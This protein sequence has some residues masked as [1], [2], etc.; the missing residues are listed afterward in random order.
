M[1]SFPSLAAVALALS[2]VFL[3]SPETN[4]SYRKGREALDRGGFREAV[5]AFAEAGK[6]PAVADAALYWQAYALAKLSESARALELVT[7][8]ENR[9]PQS[10]WKDDAQSL[11]AEIR[12]ASK[13]PRA[14]VAS[15]DEDVKLMA[16]NGLV[17]SDEE[18]AVPILEGILSGP[19]SSRLK[20]RALFVL[21]QSDSDKAQ[22]ILARVARNENDA[23]LE[24]KAIRYIG[25][26]AGDRGLALLAEL[27][28]SL[29]TTESRSAVLDAF[30]VAGE[31]GRLLAL[32]RTEPDPELRRKAIHLLGTMDASSELWE[33]FQKEGT[34][35]G[36]KAI[37]QAFMVSGNDEKLLSVAR[38]A[39]QSDELR[40]AAVRLLGAQGANDALWELYRGESSIELKK[41]ILQGLFVGGERT[42]IAEVARS[43]SEPLE[44]RKAAIRNL[45]TMGEETAPDLVA[46]Y[47]TESSPDLKEQAMN[48][49]FIQGSAKELIAL[50]R[51]ETDLE[52]KKKAVHWI[53]LMDAPEAK[54]FLMELLK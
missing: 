2:V 4:E 32:A 42:R 44:L 50:A 15:D 51:A 18:R 17:Q 24:R 39:K 26:H 37:L 48:G 33:L 45:G 25:V 36:K 49:L 54:E 12:G 46:L 38:D 23:E 19:S 10:S 8:L 14:A 5:A 31:K 28:G 6:D 27:Y 11:A 34:E 7:E 30:M 40:G 9:F 43:V 3:Q 53:S 20:E 16:L 35:E 21:A 22:E 13:S 1:L 47:R 52:L 41:Q 29:R